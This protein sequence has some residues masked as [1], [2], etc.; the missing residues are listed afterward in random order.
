MLAPV[1]MVASASIVSSSEVERRPALQTIHTTV[2]MIPAP[3]TSKFSGPTQSLHF[4]S[5]WSIAAELAK[6]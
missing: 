1:A 5:G 6:T 2:Q 4:A 3:S